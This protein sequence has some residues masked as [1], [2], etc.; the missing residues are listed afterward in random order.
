MKT[1]ERQPN[2]ES[3]PQTLQNEV[4]LTKQE[5]EEF[6]KLPKEEREKQ[7]DEQ[8]AKLK[9]LQIKLDQAI[10]EAIRTG[11][12]DEA[13]KLKDNLKTDIEELESKFY[14]E[15][16]SL[17]ESFSPEELNQKVVDS[18]KERLDDKDNVVSKGYIAYGLAGVGTPE[19]MA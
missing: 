12:L 4:A 14:I 11:D 1:P 13:K 2:I 19:S 17:S 10:Q 9:D 18:L 15:G 8:L 6:Q 7:R 5:I 3:N 16:I